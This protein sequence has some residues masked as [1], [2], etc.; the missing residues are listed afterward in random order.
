M[1]YI[2][3]THAFLWWITDDP[4]LSAKASKIIADEVNTIWFS[5]VSSWEILIKHQLGKIRFD[6]EPEILLPAQIAQNSFDIL[7]ITLPHTLSITHLENHHRD[8]FDSLLIAQSRVEG[9]PI[10]TM[11][12]NILKYSVQT[13]W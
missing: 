1:N 11:D 13:V 3:D 8:P 4:R 12:E 2:L 6:I 5:T 10:L 9:Y 7:N